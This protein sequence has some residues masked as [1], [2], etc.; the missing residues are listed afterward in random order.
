MDAVRVDR[1]RA[2]RMS[3]SIDQLFAGMAK[4]EINGSGTYMDDGLYVVETKNIFVKKGTNP[5]KPGDS[6][7]AEFTVIESNNPKHAVGS[8]GSYVLKFS[9][10][11]AMGNIVEFVMALLGYENTKENQKNEEIRKEV[12][13]VTRATCG[14][15]AAKKELGDLYEEG[16][17]R[18]IRV[19]LECTKKPTAPK[20]GKPDGGVFT[21][22]KWSPLPAPEGQPAAA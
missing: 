5:Q 4:A 20:P 10:I 16:M 19:R 22:H 11:F 3:A 18:G 1:K 15:D 7:I 2:S 8:S 9:N 21:V 6:F 12:D 17:L 13:L 14:S